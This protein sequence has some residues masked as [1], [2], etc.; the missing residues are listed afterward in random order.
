MKNS[1]HFYNTEINIIKGCYALTVVTAKL[2]KS[3]LLIQRQ[4]AACHL[5]LQEKFHFLEYSHSFT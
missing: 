5:R 2:V 1:N 3:P 4:E